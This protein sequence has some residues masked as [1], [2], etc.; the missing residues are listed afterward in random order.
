MQEVMNIAFE[1]QVQGFGS[2]SST[3]VK[4]RDRPSIVMPAQA[5]I[6]VF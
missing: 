1:F 5:G 6:Q 2:T 3:N 4:P